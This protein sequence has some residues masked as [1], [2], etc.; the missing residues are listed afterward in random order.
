MKSLT[1]VL[2]LG[3]AIPAASEKIGEVHRPRESK[4]PSGGAGTSGAFKTARLMQL[5]SAVRGQH[6]VDFEG[7]KSTFVF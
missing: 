4:N 7:E 5:S 3:E 2:H 6:E 1:T